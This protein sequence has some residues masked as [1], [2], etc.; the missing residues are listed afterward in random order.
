MASVNQMCEEYNSKF[1]LLYL[2]KDE[3]TAEYPDLS[4]KE[5]YIRRVSVEYNAKLDA[6]YILMD[7]N[8]TSYIELI[9]KQVYICRDMFTERVVG[10]VIMEYSNKNK[11]SLSE[12]LPMDLGRYLPITNK[13][14]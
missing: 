5:V 11:E 1:D 2:L 9:A 6:L 12:I 10:A 4:A 7:E 14:E 13:M 3:P 8:A